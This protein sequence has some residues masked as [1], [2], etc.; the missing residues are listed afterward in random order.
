MWGSILALPLTLKITA[1]HRVLG[2]LSAKWGCNSL[3]CVPLWVI[4]RTKWGTGCER[5]L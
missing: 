5:T 1:S 3:S 4:G 2:N